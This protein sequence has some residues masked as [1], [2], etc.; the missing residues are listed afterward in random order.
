MSVGAADQTEAERIHAELRLV[1]E[2]RAERGACEV[3]RARDSPRE[4]REAAH[5]RVV[6]QQLR[7]AQLV[8]RPR[9][10]TTFG[11]ALVL[12]DLDE[13]LVVRAAS[14]VGGAERLTA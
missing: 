14:R 9:A 4:R 7:R 2:P 8:V 1:H 3:E 5:E 10:E 13:P 12:D 6:G 11:V